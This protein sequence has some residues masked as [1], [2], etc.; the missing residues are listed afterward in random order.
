MYKH[1]FA[2]LTFVT[3]ASS[4][5]ACSSDSK[6]GGGGGQYDGADCRSIPVTTYPGQACNNEADRCWL[7]PNNAVTR[8]NGGA[9]ATGTPPQGCINFIATPDS[10][11]AQQCFVDCLKPKLVAATGSSPSDACLLCSQKVVVCGAT[12]CLAECAAAPDSAACSACLCANHSSD[13]GVDEGN[14]LQDA[15]ARCAGFRP[16]NEQVGCN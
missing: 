14:C 6:G 2:S 10:P 4:F 7:Q 9:C 12:Y 8:Q 13:A 11:D 16:T 5:A 3:L 1:I 15:F